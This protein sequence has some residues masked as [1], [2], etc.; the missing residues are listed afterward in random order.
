MFSE[1]FFNH[2]YHLL[3]SQTASSLS[4]GWPN[5]KKKKKK[6]TTTT[7]FSVSGILFLS[8]SLLQPLSSFKD[9]LDQRICFLLLLLLNYIISFHF[10]LQKLQRFHHHYHYHHPVLILY[11]L[12]LWVMMELIKKTRE[13]QK[14][15]RKNKTTMI[16]MNNLKKWRRSDRTESEY[17]IR[18][19][20]SLFRHA[21]SDDSSSLKT[22]NSFV[23]GFAIESV[24]GV[25]SF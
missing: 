8:L 16:M 5:R 20:S 4:F 2:H 14:T 17:R 15:D 3:I 1:E 11:S 13:L 18:F 9:Y 23:F 7:I 24:V 21:F 12:S 19:E 22:N 6:T 10:F 25:F